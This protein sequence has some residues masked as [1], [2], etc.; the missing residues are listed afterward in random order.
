MDEEY[1]L[2]YVFEG[3]M[4]LPMYLTESMN[5]SICFSGDYGGPPWPSGKQ[6]W[7]LI[8]GIHLCV[9]SCHQ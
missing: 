1:G 4:D 2:T 5:I 6:V 3:S 9:F 7:D 8:T